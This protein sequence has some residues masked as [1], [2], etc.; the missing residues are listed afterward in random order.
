MI[1]LADL[2]AARSHPVQKVRLVLLNFQS[3][4]SVKHLSTT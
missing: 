4:V 1:H 2:E 3:S